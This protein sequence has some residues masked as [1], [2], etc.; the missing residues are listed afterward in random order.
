MR[1]KWR[2]IGSGRL[3]IGHAQYCWDALPTIPLIISLLLGFYPSVKINALPKESECRTVYVS[4]SKGSDSNDG[5]TEGKPLKT[6]R[7]ATQK[8]NG[9]LRLRL[10]RGDVFFESISN[11]S[12]SIVE[13]YGK[14]NKPVLCGFKILKN[15]EAWQADTVNGVW[16]LH[17]SNEADFVGFSISQVSDKQCFN[18]IGCL[19]DEPGNKLYGHLVSRKD[20][21]E[22][23]GDFFTSSLFKRGEA[24]FSYLYFRYREH[25]GTLGNICLS[26]YS[27]GIS[28]LRNCI[29]RDIAITGFARHGICSINN[30]LVENCDIDIIGGSIQVGQRKWVRYGNGIECWVSDS[31]VGDNTVRHCCISRTYDCGATIQGKGNNLKSPCRIRFVGN[32]FIYCRQAFEH[33]ITAS[34]GK[35]TDYVSC[36]FSDNVCFLMGDNWFDSPE[37]RDADILSYESADKDILISNNMFYGAS[38]YCGKAFGRLRGNT[39]YIYQGQ[40]LNHYHGQKN[41]PAIYA[42]D[43]NSIEAF[44]Q[45]THDDSSIHIIEKDSDADKKLKKK[46]L[47]QMAYRPVCIQAKAFAAQ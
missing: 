23:D 24:D 22:E 27:H 8:G 40:Y 34:D 1:N 38:Y 39:V 10:K 14:G 33:F 43:E 18:N 9:N 47:K 2:H 26:T 20:L 15:L 7:K 19:Y 5:S 42:T 44:R 3:F 45:R 4:S 46:W 17:L 13:S 32:R 28:G 37:I 16:R 25:P 21:L 30:T 36:E 6:I 41:F 31:Q 12:N 11:L 29:V 35:S